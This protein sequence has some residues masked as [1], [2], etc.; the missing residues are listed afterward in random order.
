MPEEL[1]KGGWLRKFLFSVFR[2]IAKPFSKNKFLDKINTFLVC[3]ARPYVPFTPPNVAWWN[4]DKG[5]RSILDLGCGQGTAMKFINRY[6]KFLTLGVDIFMPYLRECKGQGTH[7]EYVLCDILSL[8]FQ[9]KSFDIV[10]CME[11][12]E[13]LPKEEGLELIKAIE[14]IARKQL[15]IT[16]PVGMYKQEAF[17]DNPHQKH[18]SAWSPGELTKLGFKVRGLGF[19]NIGGKRLTNRLPGIIEPLGHLVWV[20]SGPFVYFL[21]NLAGIMVRAGKKLGLKI[22]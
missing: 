10:L 18:R 11:V 17:S 13:H 9:G 8:P 1:V 22:T 16:T 14:G 19:P 6:Q 3:K 12:L 7:N 15:I 4:L 21:P 20:L 5:G 2:K